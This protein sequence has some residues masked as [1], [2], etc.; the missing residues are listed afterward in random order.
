MGGHYGEEIH[1]RL[2]WDMVY[3]AIRTTLLNRGYHPEIAT[4]VAKT[5]AD[6]VA[7]S[8]QGVDEVPYLSPDSSVM[9]NSPHW[10][11]HD[12]AAE[13]VKKAGV[14][15]EAFGRALHGAQDYYSHEGLG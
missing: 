11:S 9:A 5:I 10:W 6:R 14:S 12:E 4:I 1:Y 15:P 7:A 2:T 3:E 13:Q 8:N